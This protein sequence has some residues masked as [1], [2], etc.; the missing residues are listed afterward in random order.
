MS[1]KRI[2]TSR[3][4][5]LSRQKINDIV[6][7]A[8][9]FRE[10]IE[11]MG[12]FESSPT[13]EKRIESRMK[14]WI[15]V[16]AEGD[17]ELFERR[18]S[19]DELDSGKVGVLL[20]ARGVPP[21]DELPPWSW[22]FNEVLRKMPALRRVVLGPNVN[23]KFGFLNADRPIPF[24]ELLLPF[25]EVAREKVMDA[26][27]GAYSRL[28]GKARASLERALLQKLSWMSSRVLVVEFRTSLACR[29]LSARPYPKPAAAKGSRKEYLRFVKETYERSWMPIFE[30]YCV[31]SR[32]MATVLTQWVDGTAEF[33]DR[34]END[35]PEIRITF[36]AEGDEGKITDVHTGL[37]DS[38]NGGRAVM[39]IEFDSGAKLVYKPKDLDLEMEYFRFVAWLN[40]LR[41]FLPFLCLKVVNRTGYGWVEFVDNRACESEEE[42]RRFYRRSGAFLCLVYAANGMDFHF[43]N[44]IACGEHPVP[45]DLETIYHHL[46]GDLVEDVGLTDAVSGRLRSSVLS[47]SFLPNPVEMDDRQYYDISAIA[48][49]AEE[50]GSSEVLVWKNVN[51][52]SMD[53]SYGRIKADPSKNLPKFKDQH[54]SPDNHVEEIVDGFRQMYRLLSQHSETLLAEGSPFHRIFSQKA[55][56]LLRDTVF[57]QS[58]LRR[59]CHPDYLRDGVDFS[60]QLDGLARRLLKLKEKPNVWPLI[61]EETD[62]LWKTDV[63]KFTARGDSTCLVLQSGEVVSHCFVDSAW[64]LVIEKVWGLGEEDLQWQIDLIRGSMDARDA[65]R[66]TSYPAE[67]EL[68]GDSAVCPGKE[69]LLRHAMALAEEIRKTEIISEKG[70]PSW[71]VLKYLPEAD[72]FALRSIGFDLYDGRCGLALFFA[73]LEKA[74]PG[75]GYGPLAYSTLAL[76]RRWTGKAGA[77]D[78]KSL[79]IGGL[80]GVPSLVYSLVRIGTFLGKG[81]LLHEAAR[82]ALMIDRKQIHSDRALDVIGGA[83][84]TLLCLLACYRAGGDREILDRA[85][86]CGRHL[87]A[88]REKDRSGFRTWPTLGKKHLTGFAHGAAGIAYALLKLYVETGEREYYD[89]AKEAI[90][91]EAHEFVPERNN[92]P[93]HR[94]YTKKEEELAGPAF[95][96]TWCHGGPGIGLARLGGLDVMDSPGI[97]NDIQASLKTASQ[98]GLLPRDHICCGNMGIVETLLVAGAKLSDPE[99]TQKALRMTS[100][101]VARAKRRGS[102][103][104]TF[105]NGFFNPSLFQ[106]AAGVGYQLLRLAC[107]DE[108][109]SVLLLE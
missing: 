6:A 51:T 67:K 63:P 86:D 12:T 96:T 39:A 64:N 78:I 74:V 102:F 34:F 59:A 10:R 71:L 56:F 100:E 9:S 26:T 15:E 49:S 45:V 28:A 85:V 30:E 92:W 89:A 77:R 1:T 103:G 16:V 109:P 80:V 93:D 18:L 17:R 61:R 70:E 69:E 44:L 72:Q 105:R 22:I 107:P 27:S 54:L 79:G 81:D 14:E 66:L 21:S 108:I 41:T 48:R 87:L 35:L 3:T 20:G 75:S 4:F 52:D 13:L 31:L 97:G 33:L 42:V 88:T 65:K 29:Q 101:V 57:Y 32:L 62:A 95:M 82:T 98:C 8:S 99:W 25:I 37:S 55:R 43:E 2:T 73:A 106:G 36:L 104:V 24:E 19:F 76:V 11:R 5:A 7:K 53:F 90:D 46:S 58:L 47:T 60:I 40:D 84:G 91:F 23:E 83:A 38:H 94:E 50:E 68:D